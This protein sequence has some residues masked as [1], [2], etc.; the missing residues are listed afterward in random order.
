MGYFTM[1]TRML[2]RT[3]EKEGIKSIDRSSLKYRAPTLSGSTFK[4]SNRPRES[5]YE[6]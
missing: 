5:T 1:T 6:D 3:M 2:G 4:G